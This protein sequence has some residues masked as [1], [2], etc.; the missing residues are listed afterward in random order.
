LQYKSDWVTRY[1]LE[2][3]ASLVQEG[4]ADDFQRHKRGDFDAR[5]CADNIELSLAEKCNK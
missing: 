5:R 2:Q 1:V 4:M 3:L